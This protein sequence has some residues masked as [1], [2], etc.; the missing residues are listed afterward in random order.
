MPKRRI[1]KSC[2]NKQMTERYREYRRDYR[3]YYLD[4]MNPQEYEEYLEK[5]RIC[6]RAWRARNKDKM[7]ALVKQWRANNPDKVA[8]QRRRQRAK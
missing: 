6:N 2:N 4:N 5:M 7:A 1:C 8:E 3:K